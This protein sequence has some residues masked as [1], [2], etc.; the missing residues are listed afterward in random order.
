MVMDCPDVKN[1]EDEINIQA[2]TACPYVFVNDWSG[3]RLPLQNPNSAGTNFNPMRFMGEAGGCPI[4]DGYFIGETGASAYR[5]FLDGEYT[6]TRVPCTF[7][8]GARVERQPGN[9]IGG[10]SGLMNRRISYAKNGMHGPLPCMNKA[11]F[12]SAFEKLD[13]GRLALANSNPCVMIIAFVA[14]VQ[15]N[16]PGLTDPAVPGNIKQMQRQNPNERLVAF[17][18][19]GGSERYIVRRIAFFYLTEIVGSGSNSEYRGLML[20]AI[21]ADAVLHGPLNRS[22]GILKAQLL[23]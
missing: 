9:V 1:Y 20:Q 3:Q 15:P 4:P 2:T 11:S 16:T 12:D 13:D 10:T 5:E 21:H 23:P 8:G 22:S 18:T 7:G 19:Y 17:G 6:P 14:H